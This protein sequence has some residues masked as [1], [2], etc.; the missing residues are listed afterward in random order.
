MV[1]LR[2]PNITAREPEEKLRQ[3]ENYLRYLADTLNWALAQ[4]ERRT[5]GNDLHKK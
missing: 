5:N 2:Y 3:L 1:T 4:E